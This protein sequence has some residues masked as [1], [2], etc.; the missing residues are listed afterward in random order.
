VGNCLKQKK[1]RLKRA[2]AFTMSGSSGEDGLILRG[3]D[4]KI[5]Q[6][7]CFDWHKL[8]LNV[9]IATMLNRAHLLP[10]QNMWPPTCSRRIEIE[11]QKA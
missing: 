3:F 10:A 7:I 2:R 4:A 9:Q 6:N 11:R 8:Q 5:V 1:A